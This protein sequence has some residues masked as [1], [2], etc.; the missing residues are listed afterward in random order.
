MTEAV[1][2]ATAR[3]PLGKSFRGALNN[4]RSVT[5]GGHVI[6]HAVQRAGLPVTTA[7]LSV[8][9]FC[10]SGLQAI[11]LAAQRIVVDKVPVIGGMGAAGLFELT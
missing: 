8:N 1:I 7:A 6:H 11:A 9:R 5:L 4:T 3:T 2:V 10:S